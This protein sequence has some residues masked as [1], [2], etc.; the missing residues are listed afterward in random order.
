MPLAGTRVLDV[1]RLL[2]GP[3]ATLVLADLGAAVDK[4]EEPGVGDYLRAFPPLHD[5]ASAEFRALNRDKRSVV[6]D[7]K[8]PRGAQEGPSVR[9]R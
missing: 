7:L 1:S 5:G 8:D 2:P 3:F 9:S 6:L 4:V